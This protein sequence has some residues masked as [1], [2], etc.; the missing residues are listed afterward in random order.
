MEFVILKGGDIM[1]EDLGVILLSVGGLFCM[2]S[3]AFIVI[4]I[5]ITTTKYANKKQNDNK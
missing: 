4:K 2:G 5:M 1:T 3:I